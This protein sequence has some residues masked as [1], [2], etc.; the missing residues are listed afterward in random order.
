MPKIER[1]ASLASTPRAQAVSRP[2]APVVTIAPKGTVTEYAGQATPPKELVPRGTNV[3]KSASPSSLWGEAPKGVELSPEAFD[4][5]SGPEKKRFIETAR[6]EQRELGAEILA[7]IEVLDARWKNSRLSTRTEAL[8]EFQE[9]RGNRLDAGSRRKLDG[10]IDRSEASQRKI[11]EL[12]AKIDLLPKTPESK[13]AK[14]ELRNELARELRRARDEQSKVVKEATEVVD[15]VGLRTDRLVTTEQIIDP[16]APAPGSGES[17]LDKVQRFFKFDW[18]FNA[19]CADKT[20]DLFTQSVERRGAQ[21][22]E[23]GKAKL[24]AIR[25]K[26]NL[27]L[28]RVRNS[29]PLPLGEGQGEGLTNR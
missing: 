2:S 6:A 10:L 29:F 7:R 8:R 24:D 3:S 25:V 19:V 23:E 20:K 28:E 21:I 11:N 26:E 14:A 18:F 13:K 12:R 17:L 9:R 22:A 5:L 1:N 15:A 16:T 27:D 4:K